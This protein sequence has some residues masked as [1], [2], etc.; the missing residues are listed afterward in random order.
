MNW[1]FQRWEEAGVTEMLL[2][3]LR[4]SARRQAGS[5]RT[6]QRP[7]EMITIASTRR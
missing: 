3:E 6:A 4:I 5:R 1:Y 7:T 2:T